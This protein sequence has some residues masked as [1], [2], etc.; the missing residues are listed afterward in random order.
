MAGRRNQKQGCASKR[1]L[2]NLLRARYQRERHPARAGIEL[3]VKTARNDGRQAADNCGHA[4]T[5]VEL[6]VVMA[7]IALLAALLLPALSSAK[8]SA[9]QTS[10]LGNLRQ[11]E[12]AFQM[13]SGR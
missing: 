2:P 5:L 9:K 11:L 7:I 6:L 3:P 10:C 4:F 13:Y 1:T 12:A 8:A